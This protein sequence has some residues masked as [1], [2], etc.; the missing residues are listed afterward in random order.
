MHQQ[1][2]PNQDSMIQSDSDFF[3]PL[4]PG[5]DN[6]DYND[7]TSAPGPRHVELGFNEFV[8]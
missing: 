3:S 4:Q 1:D 5:L 6:F 2:S 8:A 7:D